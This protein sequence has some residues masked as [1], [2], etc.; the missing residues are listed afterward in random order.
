VTICPKIDSCSKVLMVLDK[1]FTFDWLYAAELKNVCE[2][3]TSNIVKDSSSIRKK[4]KVIIST[5]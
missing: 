5:V 1:D 3:C 2:V 4:K